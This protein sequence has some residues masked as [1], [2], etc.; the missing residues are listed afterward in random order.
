MMGIINYQSAQP[1][2]KKLL[3][4]FATEHHSLM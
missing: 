1:I 2:I 3:S 4:D